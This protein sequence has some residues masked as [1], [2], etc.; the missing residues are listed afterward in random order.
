MS[1]C[2]HLLGVSAC[3]YGKK[4]GGGRSPDVADVVGL[5]RE[6]G[7]AAREGGG[8]GRGQGDHSPQA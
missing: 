2:E 7:P 5:Q 4:E 3:P 6:A 1:S 8:R